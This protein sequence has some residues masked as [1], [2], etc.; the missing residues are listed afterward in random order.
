MYNHQNHYESDKVQAQIFRFQGESEV[1]EH[2]VMLHVTDPTL[3]F[4]DQL[5]A[6]Q[7]SLQELSSQLGV[8]Y[9]VFMRCF[10]SD[11]SNQ[12]QMVRD[13]F[14]DSPCALS[15]VQQPPLNG[16]KIALWAWMMT[17]VKT[18]VSDSG[19]YAVS[20]GNFRHLFSAGNTIGAKDSETQTRL[21]MERYCMQLGVEGLSL[22]ANCIRTWFFVN[23]I[24]NNYHGIVKARNDVFSGQGLTA[25]THY[26]TSTGIGGRQADPKTSSVMDAYAIDG[27]QKSQIHYLYAASHLN[28]TSDYGVA[29]ERGCYVD[30]ADRRHAFIS[31]TASIDNKGQVLYKGD[32][33][34]QTHRMLENIGALLQEADMTIEDH[35]AQMIVYLRDISDY[36]VVKSIFDQRCPGKPVVFVHAPVCRPSWLIE[37]ECMAVKEMKNPSLPSF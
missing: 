35:V 13:I 12:E 14:S 24:D 18:Q 22:E 25:K 3:P 8:V 1:T 31:G 23:D 9:P 34:R 11:A 16:T 6:I 26:I 20:H 27:I 15:V 19:L 10:I 33:V 28:R 36:A 7:H 4:A 21:I 30:Y 37:T 5:Y 32:I 17:N 29:F 2:H